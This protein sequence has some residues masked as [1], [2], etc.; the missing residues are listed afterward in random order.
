MAVAGVCLSACSY[1]LPAVSVTPP[2]F[3]GGPET[4]QILAADG[5]VLADVHGSLDRRPIP[6]SS[7]PHLLQQAVID[8]EDRHFWTEPAIDF[9]AVLRAL[10]ADVSAGR[11]AQGGSTIAEQYIKLQNGAVNDRTPGEK[12]REATA[13]W[14]LERHA[15]RS[16]ILESYLNQVY[17]GNGAYG[18]G[19]AAQAYF[20]KPV[21]QLTLSEEALLAGLIAEPSAADPFVHPAAAIQRR[22][23]VLNGM[24]SAGTI[25]AAQAKQA[26]AAPLPQAPTARGG[27]ANAGSFIGEVERFVLGDAAFGAT[28]AERTH[29]LYEGGLTISTTLSPSAEQAAEQAVQKVVPAGGPNAALAAVNP[30]DGSVLALV[31]GQSTGDPATGL[32]LA[33]SAGRPVGST[34]KPIVLAA[35]LQQ[36]IPLSTVFAAPATIDIPVTGGVWSVRNYEGEP[37]GRMNLVEATVVS[38]NVVYAQLMMQ[39][40]PQ[41]VVSLAARLGITSPLGAF[42][43]AVLGTN[44]VSPLDL[45]SVYATF[46]DRGVYHQPFM[47]TKVTDSKG[48]VLYAHQPDPGSQAITPEVA[49]TV[50]SVLQQVVNTGTAVNARIGRPVAGKTGTTDNWA[51]AWFA[52][53][54]PQMAAAVWVGYADSERPMVPPTTPFQ[55]TGGTWPAQVWQLFA[56]SALAGVPVVDFPPPPAPDAAVVAGPQGVELPSVIGLPVAAATDE[57]TSDGF[58]VNTTSAPNGQYPPGYVTA[59][60]PAPGRAQGGST[61]TLT[62]AAPG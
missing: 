47:V 52:G 45:A 30:V 54:T 55:V 53:A 46:A 36:G 5:S 57:L 59:Q 10:G 3:T 2:A 20:A 15:S 22:A 24:A 26:K 61:V 16:S 40:G 8:T 56:S 38:D 21:S 32:D 49:A 35:A 33:T 12:V 60:D 41:K 39:V 27:A 7:I 37:V 29:A 42:P 23:E 6:L 18:V 4:S 62:V 1:S 28:P 44:P 13:A 34:F 11:A 19:A 50:D 25:T 17:L 48:K 9:G 14:E 58:V 43:S 31:G 51:D